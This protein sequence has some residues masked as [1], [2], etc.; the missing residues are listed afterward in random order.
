[1]RDIHLSICREW[2]AGS[3]TYRYIGANLYHPIKWYHLRFGWH[4]DYRGRLYVYLGRFV[5]WQD[6]LPFRPRDVS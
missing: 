2:R 1:M 3:K 4:V 6:V 5:F